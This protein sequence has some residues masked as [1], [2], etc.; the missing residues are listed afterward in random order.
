V[1]GRQVCLF[2]TYDRDGIVDDYVLY[3]LS[4]I[5]AAGMLC[6]L[7]ATRPFASKSELK[8]AAPFCAAIIERENIGLDFGSWRTALLIYPELYHCQT[9][10]FANDSVYGPMRD[11]GGITRKMLAAPCDFWGIT[12]SFEV[13]P[14]YQS[15]F[16]GFKRSALDSQALFAFSSGSRY[17][18]TSARLLTA[19]KWGW[20]R[21]CGGAGCG[22]KRWCPGTVSR[23]RSKIRRCIAG[24]RRWPRARRF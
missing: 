23:V 9:L 8:K 13:Y 1:V 17:W 24:A 18:L 22:G 6:V 4:K 19:M 15:Y 3:Y 11:L 21:R 2:A 10:L 14:H 7:V 16:L 5:Q 20:W 12:E